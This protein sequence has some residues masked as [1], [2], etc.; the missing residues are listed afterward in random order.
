[1]FCLFTKGK[2]IAHIVDSDL[3]SDSVQNSNSTEQR[4]SPEQTVLDDSFEVVEKAIIVTILGYS[5]HK[6]TVNSWSR[7]ACATPQ[8]QYYYTIALL[9]LRIM[10]FTEQT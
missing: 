2:S 8:K 4:F 5:L 10:Y 7:V 9:M 1:M 3:V 6:Y